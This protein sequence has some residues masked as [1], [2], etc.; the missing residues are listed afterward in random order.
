MPE[1]IEFEVDRRIY[2]GQTVVSLVIPDDLAGEIA[3]ALR[4]G[5]G[6]DPLGQMAAVLVELHVVLDEE[7]QDA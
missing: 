4:M 3:E 5:T 1:R 7:V 6:L 2:S